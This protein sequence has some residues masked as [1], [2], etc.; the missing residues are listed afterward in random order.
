MHI[1]CL[2]S[3]KFGRR[4]H[5]TVV[6]LFFY[7]ICLLIIKIKTHEESVIDYWCLLFSLSEIN[8]L[9]L[10]L[11]KF[12]IIDIKIRNEAFFSKIYKVQTAEIPFPN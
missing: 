5:I 6:L 2:I 4:G 11:N 8:K 7:L 1:Y 12:I 10:K 3:Q 9:L